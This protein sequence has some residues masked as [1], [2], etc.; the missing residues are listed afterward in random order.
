[1]TFHGLRDNKR[2]RKD[3]TAAAQRP[4][5]TG[6][7]NG[8][9]ARLSANVPFCAQ[10]LEIWIMIPVDIANIRIGPGEPLALIAGPCVIETADTTM[11][12]AR[13]LKDLTTRIGMPLIFKAS[14]DKANRSSIQSFRGPGIDTGLDILAGVKKELGT[15]V[16]SDIHGPQDVPAAARVLD[17]IQIPAFLCRQTDLLLAAGR[18]GRPINV[19]KGQ[20]MAPWDMTNVV[21]KLRSAGCERIVLTERGASFGYNNLVSDMRSIGIMQETGCPVVFDATHS[22]QLPGGAGTRSG[23]QREF[24]PVLARAAVAAGADAVFLEVHPDPDKA[25]CDGPNSMALDSLEPLLTQLSAIHRLV[26]QS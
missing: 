26:A 22:I 20:F 17:V 14:F 5:G 24:A 21:T 9:V 8:P 2:L 25:L 16:I 19:K 10:L 4:V 13:Y 23:G 3:K 6:H 18:S 15:P 12:I 7:H 1:L 11:E